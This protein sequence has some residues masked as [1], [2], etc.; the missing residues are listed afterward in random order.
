MCSLYYYLFLFL[1]SCC[2]LFILTETTSSDEDKNVCKP[3]QLLVR[4]FF[5]GLE[6][7][8]KHHFGGGNTD[9]EER[10]LGR[11]LNRFFLKLIC[12]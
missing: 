12:F 6:Y 8:K 4:T 11:F 2:Y 5:E 7:T 10:K 3:C 9:W 1:N